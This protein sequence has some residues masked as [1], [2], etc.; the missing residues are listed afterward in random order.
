MLLLASFFPFFSSSFRDRD[1]L[2][3]ATSLLPSLPSRHGGLHSHLPG[4]GERKKQKDYTP[5]V[6]RRYSL[7]QMTE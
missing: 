4:E 1:I 5:N 3:D 6:V 2:P 7:T